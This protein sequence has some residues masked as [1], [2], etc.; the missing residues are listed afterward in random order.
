MLNLIITDPARSEQEIFAY[1]KIY[2]EAQ[3]VIKKYNLD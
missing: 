2:E 1:S 3:D